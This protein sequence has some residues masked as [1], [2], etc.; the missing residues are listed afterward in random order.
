MAQT[1]FDT[2]ATADM[3]P[4]DQTGTVDALEPSRTRTSSLWTL[5]AVAL[6]VLLLALIFISQNS[7]S[8]DPEFLW[9]DFSLPLGVAFLLAMVL[10]GLL[11]VA[12]GA[13]RVVQLRLAARR[14]RG[15]HRRR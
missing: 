11:V 6:L 13:A 5:T 15:A 7:E 1:R 9:F 14:H 4:S 3:Q 10:G 12:I 2:T 8:V